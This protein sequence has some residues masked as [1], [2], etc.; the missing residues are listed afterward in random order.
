VQPLRLFL[1]FL[2]S[3]LD[4]G[5]TGSIMHY[6]W[7]FAVD[8]A[9]SASADLTGQGLIESGILPVDHFAVVCF[10]SHGNSCQ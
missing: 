10:S 6:R 4:F 5:Y 2:A 9:S 3:I 1:R 7:S 8:R